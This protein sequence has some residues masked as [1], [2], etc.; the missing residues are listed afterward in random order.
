MG[1]FHLDIAG[2]STGFPDWVGHE[3]MKSGVKIDGQDANWRNQLLGG[4]FYSLVTRCFGFES[5]G[6]FRVRV[7]ASGLRGCLIYEF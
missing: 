4:V 3:V 6:S 7:D 5:L 1:G 2:E